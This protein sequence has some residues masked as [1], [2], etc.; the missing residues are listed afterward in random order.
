MWIFG[1]AQPA[2]AVSCKR[3]TSV[4]EQQ[5][6]PESVG[7]HL[8]MTQLVVVGSAGPSL[9]K[10]IIIRDVIWVQGGELKNCLHAGKKF[11]NSLLSLLKEKKK[12]K[13]KQKVSKMKISTS[14]V[15][16]VQRYSCRSTTAHHYQVLNN[17]Y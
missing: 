2:C 12:E 10:D 13:Q 3:E 1:A 17:Q 16:L 6:T 8:N 5:G 4:S 11:L 14:C 9:M 7:T 15:L